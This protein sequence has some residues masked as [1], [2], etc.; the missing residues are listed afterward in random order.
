MQL[1]AHYLSHSL[2][3]SILICEREREG[4][5]TGEERKTDRERKREPAQSVMETNIERKKERDNLTQNSQRRS[6]SL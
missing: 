2:L 5:D 6:S 3:A 1:T 4:N